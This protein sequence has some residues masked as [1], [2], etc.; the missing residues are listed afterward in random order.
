MPAKP[1]AG[2]PQ[3]ST[4]KQVDQATAEVST[5]RMCQST[6]RAP[7][8]NKVEQQIAGVRNGKPFTH[9]V[10]RRTRCLDCGQ[11]R[12]DVTWENRPAQKK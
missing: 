12:S 2:R 9:I 1:K 4:N 10:W 3:G 8:M 7:Y 5:C 6:R 11:H